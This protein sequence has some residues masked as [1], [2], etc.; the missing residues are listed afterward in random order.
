M[1]SGTFSD[2]N[3]QKMVLAREVNQQPKL[4]LLNQ[5]TLGVDIAGVELVYQRLFELRESGGAILLVSN[6][7]DE[8]I[9][10]ADHVVVMFQGRVVKQLSKSQLSK[11]KLGLLGSNSKNLT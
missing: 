3:Q 4:L 5:P 11:Q 8:V 10:L 6:D 1:S 2:G 7:L 9:S